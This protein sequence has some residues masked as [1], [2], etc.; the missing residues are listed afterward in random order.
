MGASGADHVPA[1]EFFPKLFTEIFF[2]RVERKCRQEFAVGK[3]GQTVTVPRNTRKAFHMAI[4]R[5]DVLVTDGPVNCKT[6]PRGAF[7]IVIAPALG[8]PGPKQGASTHLVPPDP[9]E[10]LLLDVRVL[11]IF[12]KEM[13]CGFIEGIT[14]VHDGIFLPDRKRQFSAML[15]FEGIHVCRGIVLDVTDVASPFQYQRFQA[16]FG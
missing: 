9:V 14:S 13:L 3:F 6:I 1:F 15:E 10:L 5:R 16:L 4:P 11:V 8:L 2:Y 12:D 7:E